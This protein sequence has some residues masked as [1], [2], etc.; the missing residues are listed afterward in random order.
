M[1]GRQ[2]HERLST[3][4]A[5]RRSPKGDGKSMWLEFVSSFARDELS[6]KIGSVAAFGVS[7]SR[8]H[9]GG[10]PGVQARPHV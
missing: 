4:A 2:A 10:A 7:P 9:F 5:E 8:I 6:L 3:G 1:F